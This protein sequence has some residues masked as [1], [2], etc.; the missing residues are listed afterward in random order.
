M[1]TTAEYKESLDAV[2]N[3]LSKVMYEN[4]HLKIR[5]EELKAE[6]QELKHDKS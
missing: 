6:V 4:H 1:T 2:K 5:V 3:R